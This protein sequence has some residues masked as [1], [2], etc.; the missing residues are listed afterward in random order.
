MQEG[1]G[2]NIQHQFG[3][4]NNTQSNL[5]NENVKLFMTI[6]GSDRSTA[7]TFLSRQNSLVD[8]LNDYF[9][10]PP[11]TVNPQSLPINNNR[12]RRKLKIKKK[13]P[14]H[15]RTKMILPLAQEPERK[16]L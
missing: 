14:G 3:I 16:E 5:Q 15:N 13:I 10:N 9:K 7:S 8:A 4:Q 2:T 11:G 12:L 6:T 1:S